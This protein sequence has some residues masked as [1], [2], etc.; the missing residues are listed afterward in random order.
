[1]LAVL[2]VGSYLVLYDGRRRGVSLGLFRGRGPLGV[3]FGGGGSRRGG[4]PLPLGVGRRGLTAS[5]WDRGRSE[6]DSG[7]L[8]RRGCISLDATEVLDK[9]HPE[10]WFPGS[11]PQLSS[12]QKQGE[13]TLKV[14]V[15]LVELCKFACCDRGGEV[16]V[17]G[18]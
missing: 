14:A 5:G 3:D 1:M 12:D 4:L 13:S 2:A 18:E 8:V 9:V 11:P 16:T 17:K 10:R 6:D 7:F 15:A